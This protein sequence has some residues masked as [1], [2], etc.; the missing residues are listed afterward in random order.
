MITSIGNYKELIGKPVDWKGLM[1][2][3]VISLGQTLLNIWVFIFT[4]FGLILILIYLTLVQE[5]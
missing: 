4:L 3:F 2:L 1:L 5:K